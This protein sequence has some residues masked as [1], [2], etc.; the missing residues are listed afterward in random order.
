MTI[1][2]ISLPQFKTTLLQTVA[3]APRRRPAA[4]SLEELY[5]LPPVA[6]VTPEEA[7]HVIQLTESALAVRR[8]NG[9]WPRYLK[10][11][12]LVRYRLGDLM[13]APNEAVQP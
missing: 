5:K 1:N 4:R 13:I 6:L 11:G 10:F 2:S 12:R 8:S 7:A 9:K 3:S